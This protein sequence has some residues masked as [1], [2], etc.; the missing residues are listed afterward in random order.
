MHIQIIT[1]V[2]KVRVLF[3]AYIFF[4]GG[5]QI[6][7]RGAVTSKTFPFQ[8][9]VLCCGSKTSG[10]KKRFGKNLAPFFFRKREKKNTFCGSSRL[11]LLVLF[12]KSILTADRKTFCLTL[13]N[14]RGLLVWTRNAFFCVQTLS[15]MQKSRLSKS[16][17]TPT[18]CANKAFAVS[19]S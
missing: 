10:Y 16:I 11:E 1:F 15:W 7:K 17:L 8:G 9:R 13:R 4:S 2:V 5:G 14:N 18:T 6:F 12:P 3:A 19:A